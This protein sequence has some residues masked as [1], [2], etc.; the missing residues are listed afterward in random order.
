MK[1]G[2]IKSLKNF[3]NMFLLNKSLECQSLQQ[4][5]V[6]LISKNIL[7]IKN[8]NETYTHKIVKPHGEHT[9]CLKYGTLDQLY[10]KSPSFSL[11]NII[12]KIGKIW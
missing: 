7:E 10:M 9:F 6:F 1:Q 4:I 8:Q 2:N 3:K 5:L 11:K 12:D